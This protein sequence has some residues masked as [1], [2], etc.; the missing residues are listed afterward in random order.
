M[1]EPV[2]S[3][4]V[5]APETSQAE[6]TT[7][8]EGNAMGSSWTKEDMQPTES[9]KEFSKEDTEPTPSL[10]VRENETRKNCVHDWVETSRYDD[11]VRCWNCT[12]CGAYEDEYDREREEY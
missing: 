3:V 6:T 4:E 10:K 8:P 11:E 5:Q 9:K 1:R 12:K 7:E 2:Q